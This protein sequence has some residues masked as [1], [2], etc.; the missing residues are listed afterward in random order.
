MLDLLFL[1]LRI[2]LMRI[3]IQ[4]RPPFIIIPQQDLFSRLVF[5]RDVFCGVGF[6]AV[7]AAP[8]ERGLDAL[9]GERFGPFG[10]AEV[11]KEAVAS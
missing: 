6:D 11:A 10:G 9:G 3:Q 8:E 7:F 1:P 2:L 5:G 4:T